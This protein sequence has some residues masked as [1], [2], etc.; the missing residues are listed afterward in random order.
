MSRLGRHQQIHRHGA[1]AEI[2]HA[3]QDLHQRQRRRRQADHPAV[4]PEL[5]PLVSE[6]EPDQIGDD[7][8]DNAERDQPVDRRRQLIHRGGGRG[9]PGHADA[10][11]KGVAEPEGQAGKKA[12]LGDVDGAE[13]IIRIDP[14]TDRAAGE[15]GCADIVADRIAGEARQRRDTIGHM[16]LA[17]RAYRKEIIERQ[18]AEARRPRIARPT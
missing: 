16:L 3:D 11:H 5:A 7:S 9:L 17:E 14:E 18:G 6:G 8:P 4:L 10:E 2:D 15:D 13:A 12:D 1:E